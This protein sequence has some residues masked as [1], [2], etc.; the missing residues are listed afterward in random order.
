[1]RKVDDWIKGYM[2]YTNNTES[3]DQFRIW[4]AIST[5]AAALQ[6]RCYLKWGYS[7]FYPNMYI[8][9]VGP[10]GSRKGTAMKPAI[11]IA[12]QVEEIIIASN[13]VTEQALIQDLMNSKRI[14]GDGAGNDIVHSSLTVFS[15]EFTVF[16]GYDNK[17]LMSTLT[18]WYDCGGEEHGKWVYKT[19]GRGKETIKGIWLN[20]LG[21]TTPDLIQSTL[22]KE[23]IGGGLTSRMVMVFSR[24]KK[25]CVPVP[26]LSDRQEELARHLTHDLKQITKLIGEFKVTE[27]FMNRYIEWYEY[28]HNN[29]RFTDPRLQ[30]YLERRAPHLLK[31]CMV[32]TA[33]SGDKMVIGEDNFERALSYLRNAEEGMPYVFSGIGESDLSDIMERVMRTIA[34]KGKVRRYELLRKYGH[35]ADKT[36]MDDVLSTLSAKKFIS[37]ERINTQDDDGVLIEYIGDNDDVEG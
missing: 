23:A 27:S 31:L 1:M 36:I 28:Q 5:V 6:R 30:G 14:Y 32:V 34:I 18:D 11:S 21:A 4:T 29:K 33:S 10:S 2:E 17:Q 16:T 35:D 19:I 9:L 13:S 37:L 20:V 12:K 26:F 25:K 24:G 3:S 15:E 8:V 7:T 22:P